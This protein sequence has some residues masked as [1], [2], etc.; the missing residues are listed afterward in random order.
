MPSNEEKNV[1][2]NVESDSL[3]IDAL[4]E[5]SAEEIE[6]LLAEGAGTRPEEPK[7]PQGD[8]LDM[9]EEAG[10]SADDDLMDIQDMLKKSDRNE[11][12]DEGAAEET[13][14]RQGPADR[15][16]ADIE[17]AEAAEEPADAKA[18]KAEKKSRKAQEK[19]E[20]AA[21]RKAE[22]EAAKAEKAAKRGKKRGGKD[23][24][25]SEAKA[26]GPGEI[27]EYDMLLD[28]D[29]LDSIVSDAGNVGRG[30][31]RESAREPGGFSVNE[32]GKEYD[33]ALEREKA[34]EAERMKER[35][36]APVKEETAESD[37]MELD[38]D[39]IDAFIPDIS[40]GQKEEGGAKRKGGLMTKIITMLTE[41]EPENEDIP[42]SEENEEILK[43]LDKEKAGGKKA[44]KRKR[45]RKSVV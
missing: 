8:V 11:A 40:N 41:E 2:G 6:K 18:R 31:E 28:K 3:G 4:T 42:L 9:L 27:E 39:E 23:P 13:G 25:P 5:L 33:A 22:K 44:K 7:E 17:G 34:S 14:S 43:D 30:E 12:I 1:N 19:A 24:E 36:V 15:L 38:M 45:D 10:S 26:E 37:I 16:L 21:R 29:L 20:K 32:L 35:D